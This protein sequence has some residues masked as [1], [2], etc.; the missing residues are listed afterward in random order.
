MP[1][2]EKTIE[3]N[4]PVHTAYNQWTQFEEFPR[5]MEGVHEV[6]QQD[7]KRLHWRA[8]I[9]G[10]DKE[11]DAEITDQTPDQRIAW[12]SIGGA[13]NGG[14]VLFEPLAADRTRITLRIDYNPDDFVETVGGAL[15]FVGRRVEGDLK[16]F[17][18]F[19]E[20]RGEETGAWRGE[21]HGKQVESDSGV[22]SYSGEPSSRSARLEQESSG[23]GGG[24]AG[25]FGETSTRSAASTNFTHEAEVE[26][27]S[28][29]GNPRGEFD[30]GYMEG[31]TGGVTGTNVRGSSH[32]DANEATFR[33]TGADTTSGFDERDMAREHGEDIDTDAERDH[34]QEEHRSDRAA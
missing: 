4:V 13:E 29:E 3:V 12:R 27:R 22:T 2:V 6:R 16:R 31:A 1:D 11:W 24:S 14:A 15:G 19:V 32:S 33:D 8:E 5:F 26:R 23:M 10:R 18:E 21:I 17:R 30:Q 20:A 34:F 7:D 28:A 9:A 25:A